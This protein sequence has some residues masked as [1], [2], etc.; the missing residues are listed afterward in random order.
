MTF[1]CQPI[2]RESLQRAVESVVRNANQ[3]E[4]PRLVNGY[5]WAIFERLRVE[6]PGVPEFVSLA[7]AEAAHDFDEALVMLADRENDR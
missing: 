1:H 4:P 7:I 3:P 2:T 6:R 5:T